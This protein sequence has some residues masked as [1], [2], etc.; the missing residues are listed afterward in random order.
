MEQWQF[1]LVAQ[2]MSGH[3]RHEPSARVRADLLAIPWELDGFPVMS[4]LGVGMTRSVWF[5]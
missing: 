3:G 4:P 5:L 2:I 1:S